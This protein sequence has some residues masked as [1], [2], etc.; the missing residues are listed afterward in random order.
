[1]AIKKLPLFKTPAGVAVYPHLTK[2]D[3]RFVPE[4]QYQVKLRIPSEE[5]QDLIESLDKAFAEAQ[6]T[7]KEKN[8]G[9]KIKEAT[10][11][12]VTEEDDEGNETGNIVV[13]F[14]CKAQITD[15]QGNTR[16]NSP[17]IFDSKNKEFPKDEEIWGGSTLRVAFNA[18]PY[19]TAMAGAGISLRLKAVQIIDLVSGG[20]GGN[21][22]SYGFGEEDGYVA[23]EATTKVATA[24]ADE[25]EEDNEDF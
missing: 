15:K 18:I 12:Y 4:G 10:K 21:G 19:Y 5:A 13:S 8:P 23:P 16:V 3:T 2:P 20:G 6:E 1:M 14:K 17:K 24:D 22:A 9:K 25:T 11:P 7:A